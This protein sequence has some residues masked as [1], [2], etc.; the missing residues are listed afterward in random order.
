MLY[1]VGRQNGLHNKVVLLRFRRFS[2]VTFGVLAALG[3]AL[4]TWF[5]LARQIQAGLGPDRY[6]P[7]LFILLPLLIVH[8]SRLM[9][10]A[11]E[12][13][14]LLPMP[15]EPARRYGLAFQGGFVV[16]AA[17]VIGIAQ[18]Y[19][20]DLLVLLDTFALGIPL[21]HALGRLGCH[22]YGCCH[23]KPT[24]SR[25]SL[26]YTNPESKVVWG[27]NLGGVPLHPTQLYSA[28]GNLSL[29]ALLNLLAR[30]PRPAGQLSGLFLILG[31]AGRF[32]IEFLRGI[33]T[34]RVAGLTPFQVAAALL[35]LAGAAMLALTASGEALLQLPLDTMFAAALAAAGRRWWYIAWVFLVLLLSFSFRGPRVGPGQGQL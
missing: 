1:D 9:V 28:W 19:R 30:S 15:E 6:G 32:G 21:G 10:L 27:S 35:F 14:R 34:G 4:G 2:I 24:G 26:R 31:S 16:A 18:L 29:F 11:L 3:A 7:A 20:V 17:G 13:L 22:T 25:I 8:G 23:G 5:I 12:Q 33:P